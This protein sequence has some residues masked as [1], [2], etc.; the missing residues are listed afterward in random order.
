VNPNARR[1]QILEAAAELFGRQGYHSTSISNI[2]KAAKIARGTFYLYFENKR[3]I[4]EE[5]LDRLVLSIH[6]S[7]DVVDTSTDAPSVRDQVLDNIVRVLVLL[8]KNKPLLS[9]LLEGAV[10]LDKGFDEK[11]ADF[12]DKNARLIESSLRLGQEMR[13]VRPCDAQV[14]AIAGVGTLKEVLHGM[15]RQGGE[16]ADPRYVAS[17]VLD[18]FSRGVLVDG[19]SLK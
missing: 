7:I 1:E 5:L 12:Y 8:T 14:A 19:V 11:L 17:Q 13:I 9:I 10:G 2:I 6:D 4:F 18:I 16:P 3:A 15:L